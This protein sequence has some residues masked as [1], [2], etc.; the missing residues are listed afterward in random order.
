MAQSPFNLNDDV[1]KSQFILDKQLKGLEDINV[2]LHARCEKLQNMM[3]LI[4]QDKF[5]IE[6]NKEWHKLK[7][8]M[9]HLAE[10][11]TT[12]AKNEIDLGHKI[13]EIDKLSIENSY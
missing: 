1:Y 4:G 2:V 5:S 8:M 7:E 9:N 10:T 3:D 6:S 13:R 11:L 12:A